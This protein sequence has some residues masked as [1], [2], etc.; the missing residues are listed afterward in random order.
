MNKESRSRKKKGGEGSKG[1]GVERDIVLRKFD[2]ILTFQ[3]VALACPDRSMYLP[4]GA[5]S[6]SRLDLGFI[7]FGIRERIG[8]S[9]SADRDFPGDPTSYSTGSCL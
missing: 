9:Q 3:V 8:E 4:S 6:N 2:T 7:N 5:R 1:V